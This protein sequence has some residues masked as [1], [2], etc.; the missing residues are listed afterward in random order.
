MKT[1]FNC[2][3]IFA[4]CSLFIGDSNA[5][6]PWWQQPTVCRLDPTNCYSTMGAGFDANMGCNRK[7]LGA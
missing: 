2:S 4:L 5:A 6:T 1:I 7:M 3:F